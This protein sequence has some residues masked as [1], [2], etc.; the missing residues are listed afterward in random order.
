MSLS[1]VDSHR[2][3]EEL[4]RAKTYQDMRDVIREIDQNSDG[5]VSLIEWLLFEFKKSVNE[6][7]G[8]M[9]GTVEK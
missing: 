5:R 2:L 7:G 9:R 1:E 6:V 4:G 3:L 8:K